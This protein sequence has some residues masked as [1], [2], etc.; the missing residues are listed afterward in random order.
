M[1]ARERYANA[2]G[3]IKERDHKSPLGESEREP[4]LHVCRQTAPSLPSAVDPRVRE[5][6][7]VGFSPKR[8]NNNNHEASPTVLQQSLEIVMYFQN[9]V[10]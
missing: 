8:C 7:N 1:R 3:M 6:H 4:V 2:C 5:P 9:N 10:R